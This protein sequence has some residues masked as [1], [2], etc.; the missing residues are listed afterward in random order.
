MFGWLEAAWEAR[1]Y[2]ES[3]GSVQCEDRERTL[4]NGR[5]LM[6][7]LFFSSI[8]PYVTVA[9]SHHHHGEEAVSPEALAK[10]GTVSFPISCTASV[11]PQFERG[12]A[13]MHS[14]W[15]EEARAQFTAVAASDPHCAM[16]Q[17]GLAM[18]EWRPLWDGKPESRRQSGIAEIDKAT[19]LHAP[20]DHERRYIT[21]LSAYLHGDPAS[22]EKALPAYNAARTSPKT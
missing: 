13:M 15:Y 2:D 18:T 16:A 3:I 14:F 10:V 6:L 17:W 12:V 11:Q 7:F 22:N 4:K 5:I 1:T 19:A 8:L 21:A 9:Q 20:T